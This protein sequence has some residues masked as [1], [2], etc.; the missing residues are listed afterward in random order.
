MVA[1]PRFPLTN[2]D[3]QPPV[4]ADLAEQSRD[5]RFVIDSLLAGDL[6]RRVD[7]DHIGL[8]GL[9]FGSL[10]VWGEVLGPTPDPRVDAVVQ[11]DGATLVDD[12]GA[13]PFPVFVAHSDVDPIFPYA[14]VV[15]AY[16]ELPGPKYLLT[17]HAAVHATVGEDTVTPAD[18]MYRQATTVG[19]GND[20]LR[21][22]AAAPFPDSLEGVAATLV[23]GARPEL[24][25]GTPL[26]AS[27]SA[28]GCTPR[29]PAIAARRS[30]SSAGRIGSAGQMMC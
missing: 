7:A 10:T 28:C 26:N 13:V 18:E 29:A 17:L 11:S 4:L 23:S 21:G 25:P 24:L 1:A 3:V 8:F 30:S 5:V 20:T 16:D 6:A 27:R 2:E 22:D 14:D 9:S 12:I 19:S 15:A